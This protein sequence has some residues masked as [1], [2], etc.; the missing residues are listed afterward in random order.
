M[1]MS[2]MTVEEIKTI[3][4]VEWF[5][6]PTLVIAVL[7]LG[8]CTAS[9][10]DELIVLQKDVAQINTANGE[11]KKAIKQ[12]EQDA[13]DTKVSIGKIEARQ[14]SYQAHF[15]QQMNNIRAQNTEILR[16]IRDK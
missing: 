3:R 4:W 9:A 13:N 15:T 10:Q 2:E 12:I 7:S 14:E 6:A 11:T 5:L 1:A 16:L 8:K